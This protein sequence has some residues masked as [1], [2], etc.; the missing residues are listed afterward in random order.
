MKWVFGILLLC[1]VGLYLWT[2]GQRTDGTESTR[3]PENGETMKLLSEVTPAAN[4]TK[5]EPS[6]DQPIEQSFCLRIGPFFDINLASESGEKLA[7]LA[8]P[9]KARSV[10]ARAIR[11]Y[12]VY[13]GPFT[14][15]GAAQEQRTLLNENGITDHYVK[16]QSGEQDI[17]SLGLFIQS[18]GADA[19]MEQLEAK[20]IKP[21]VRTE[22]RTLEPTYWLEL[23]D[24]NANRNSES[25][26]DAMEWGDERTKLSEFPCA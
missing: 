8:L 21:H 10:K 7:S 15:S 25:R 1:N 14:S 11:A 24:S 23:R 18:D 4:E 3:P 12:R 5:A 19:L 17:I 22:D 20:D 13:L 9:F 6:D 16:R 2:Y 26:L